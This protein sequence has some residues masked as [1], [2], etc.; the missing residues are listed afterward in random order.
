MPRVRTAFLL[1]IATMTPAIFA[2]DG[3]LRRAG[4]NIR[5]RVETEVARGQITA[6]EREVLNRVARR[7]EWDKQSARS[8]L[9][10]EAQ[11]GGVVIVR[12]SVF[13]AAAKRR[14]VDLAESTVGV[15]SV[16]DEVA[17]VKEVKVIESPPVA[18]PVVEVT[19]PVV[20]AP[21]ETKVIV[22]P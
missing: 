22:K 5:D 13:D 7:I 20:V 2:Q 16:V 21:V 3:P 1:A 9:Q 12:G 17:V 15:T 6:Q 10:I 14:V 11:P 8:T 19:A 18:A 4:R